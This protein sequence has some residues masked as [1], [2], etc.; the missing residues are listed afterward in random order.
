M[1]RPSSCRDDDS[2]F[3]L[4]T[5]R[6]Y[7]KALRLQ[8]AALGEHLL[9][10]IVKQPDM[11]AES[12][13][14]GAGEREATFLQGKGQETLSLMVLAGGGSPPQLPS[15]PR[16]DTGSLSKGIQEHLWKCQMH[17]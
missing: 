11:R 12:T 6:L 9:G 17:L 14:W 1:T 13:R 8:Q 2:R 10:I 3:E 7:I 4:I 5:L 15:S 16:P